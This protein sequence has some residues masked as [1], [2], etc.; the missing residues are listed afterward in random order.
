[1]GCR[2]SAS[3]SVQTFPTWAFVIY[4]GRIKHT[5]R[6]YSRVEMIVLSMVM[7]NSIVWS[8]AMAN[9]TPQT[10][11]RQLT[12]TQ[13]QMTNSLLHV[14]EGNHCIFYD[15]GK[16]HCLVYGYGKCHAPNDNS[17]ARST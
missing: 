14:W 3:F 4:A 13:Y 10:H 17:Q 11:K 16:C 9:A 15:Y 8:M 2:N 5:T 6:P 12:D 1:M 7:A